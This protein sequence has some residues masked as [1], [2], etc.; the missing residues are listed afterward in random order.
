MP[1]FTNDL[2][3][4]QISFTT[5]MSSSLE[6]GRLTLGYISDVE[7]AGTYVP[8]V[9]IPYNYYN[10]YPRAEHEFTL[11]DYNLPSGVRLAFRWYSTSSSERCCIDDIR[12]M[13]TPP[14][15]SV[16]ENINIL[17]IEDS[18]I[19]F[20]WEGNG[21]ESGWNIE[22]GVAGFVLGTGIRIDHATSPV[23]INNLAAHTTYDIYI[24]SICTDGDLSEW[25]SAFSITTQCE[26]VNI[27]VANPFTEYFTQY[28]PVNYNAEGVIPDCW[29]SASSGNSA[30]L[31]V[32]VNFGFGNGHGNALILTSGNDYGLSNYIVLPTIQ[33]AYN[34]L[35]LSF[36]TAMTNVVTGV[37]TLGYVSTFGD[38]SSYVIL[39][40]IPN[41]NC[42]APVLH[43][44][45]LSDYAIPDGAN[46]A[47]RWQNF[48]GSWSCYLDDI[49][50]R[51][52]EC[53]VPTNISIQSITSHSAEISWTAASMTTAYEIEYGLHDFVLG[54]GTR[55]QVN[56]NSYVL[57]NLL[58]N[59]EYDIYVRSVCGNNNESDWSSVGSF[60]T[61][62]NV[63]IL[64]YGNDFLLYPNPANSSCIIEGGKIQEIRVLNM[65]GQLIQ[66]NE[67][68]G[69]QYYKIDVNNFKSGIYIICI[70]TIEQKVLSYKLI[71]QH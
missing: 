43:E 61:E 45:Q 55:V 9:N 57:N 16:P 2:N 22:Y 27:T 53:E 18:S 10:D 65:H 7:S 4:L 69:V 64:E 26:T 23:T 37:F 40:T 68:S 34:E 44:F 19:E 15:C 50:I 39:E 38:T 36:T 58:P 30:P 11:G 70:V 63:S 52:R 3:D 20:A 14:I 29:Y 48:A 47:F 5:A 49:I 67:V 6:D 31:S 41:N 35:E 32:H 33:N 12:L 13:I 51:L 1:E 8:V 28:L 17:D 71:V 62:D 42:N 60:T 21:L 59:M 25:S 46:L 54:T 66:K 24:Q 56:G